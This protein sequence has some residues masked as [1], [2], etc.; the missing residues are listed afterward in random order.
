MDKREFGLKLLRR[1]HIHKVISGPTLGR[2][3]IFS[4]HRVQPAEHKA[5]AP[6]RNLTIT[7]DFLESVIVHMRKLGFET[8]SLDDAYLR[9]MNKDAA[10]AHQPFVCFTFDDGYR[11]NWHRAYP[12][13]AK[14]KV[15]FT[16]FVPS[17]FAEGRGVLWWDILDR[18]IANSQVVGFE[19]MAMQSC[20]TAEE[21]EKA[22]CD[23]SKVLKSEMPSVAHAM[24]LRLAERHGLDSD[25]ICRDLIMGWDELAEFS[26][27]E[28]AS[29]GGHT[30]NH[31]R[32]AR[33]SDEEA[34]AEMQVGLDVLGERL[35]KR[36][37]HFSYPFGDPTS[38]GP[39]EF[40]YA[41]K[42]GIKIGVTTNNSIVSDSHRAMPTALPR[43]SLNRMYGD[44]HCLEVLVSGVQSTFSG[45][46]SKTG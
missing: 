33:L 27:L 16:V 45:W 5:F 38:A 1:L 39:R 41:H 6:N 14:H 18:V 23:L 2:G 26:R 32:L 12:V 35:G 42:L 15:P 17:Q 8:L 9:L 22:F 43:L 11:D 44:L 31:V 24:V 3:V 30:T 34:M 36:P 4:A 7:P 21:K 37:L 13:L 46:L 28:F 29:I 40:G 25:G 10:A 19:G 20:A